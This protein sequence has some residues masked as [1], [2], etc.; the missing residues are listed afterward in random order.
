M[1]AFYKE[2]QL[3]VKIIHNEKFT[4]FIRTATT[5]KKCAV[6][7]DGA[8]PILLDAF[9]SSKTS[10]VPSYEAPA[11]SLDLYCFSFERSTSNSLII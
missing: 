4:H 11:R 9:N 2:K 7:E 8:L 5:K 1:L 6:K 3:Q 10:K